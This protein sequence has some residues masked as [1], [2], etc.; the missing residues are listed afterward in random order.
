MTPPFTDL[1]E[2]VGVQEQ[3][4]GEIR[5]PALAFEVPQEASSHSGSRSRQPAAQGEVRARDA[6]AGAISIEMAFG[7]ARLA[8]GA[9]VAEQP[10]LAQSGHS[11][12]RDCRRCWPVS[13]MKGGDGER[14]PRVPGPLR[15][16]ARGP[17]SF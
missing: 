12:S 10:R 17:P 2:A 4:W 3:V 13:A 7:A 9:K 11:P 16:D 1:G 14:A 6:E 5:S 15:G 8:E